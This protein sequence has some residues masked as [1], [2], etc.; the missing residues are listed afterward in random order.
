MSDAIRDVRK[1]ILSA[2]MGL[3]KTG[4]TLHA[5]SCLLKERL[6]RKALV[7]APLRVAQTTWPDEIGEWSFSANIPYT[8]IRS[9]DD[10][11]EVVSFRRS[12]YRH[13]RNDF[14]LESSY[15]SVEAG[16][17]TT[18]FKEGI[19]RDL[20]EDDT[21]IHIINRE[22]IPWLVRYWGRYW[23]YDMLIYDEAS[24]L[25]EGR[26]RS[27][28]GA[29]GSQLSEFGSLARVAR[30][31]EY[32]ALLSGTIAPNGPID[33]WG[34]LYIIDQGKRLGT[35]KTAFKARWFDENKFNHT[36]E[37]KPAAIREITDRVKDVMFS[38]KAK[39]HLKDLPEE[40]CNPIYGVLPEHLMDRYKQFER[41]SVSIA[42]DIEAVNRGVLTNKLLQFANG[43]MY[44]NLDDGLRREVIKIHDIKLDMLDSVLEEAGSE[45]VLL[46]YSFEFDRD[47]IR[48][49]FKHAVLFDGQPDF[50][51]QW[52]N[53]KIRFAIA[54]PASIGHGLNLQ[55]GG[56]TLVWYGL[57]W[58][59]ELYQQFNKRLPR[60]GQPSPFVV[61]H[62]LLMKGTADEDAFREMS[63]KDATQESVNRRV[64]ANILERAGRG[65]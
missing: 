40:I 62:H 37:P 6:V 64:R 48:K 29:A 9:E 54:H 45:P 65:P 31:F 25:K 44:R 41:D 52:N 12:R 34:P 60:S 27:E 61:A 3:G 15:A 7:V 22:A 56:H 46:A 42:Y 4:A 49:R 51:K 1:V 28:G 20:A 38:L 39:D 2:E 24:R 32:V 23:P 21:D 13:Y 5:T 55:F 19:R 36:I 59:L 10:D 35:K 53:R 47:A 18:V 57:N 11:P 26:L 17:D 43:S 58:S 16:R 30:R 50:I 33:L 8:L 63:R 14:F